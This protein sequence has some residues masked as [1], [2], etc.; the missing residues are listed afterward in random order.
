ME[1]INKAELQVKKKFY[2]MTVLKPKEVDN[3]ELPERSTPPRKKSYEQRIRRSSLQQSPDHFSEAPCDK[4]RSQKDRDKKLIRCLHQAI[5][6]LQ[7]ICFQSS[8][9]LN[10]VNDLLDL[11]KIDQFKFKLHNDYFDLSK[12]VRKAAGTM[13]PEAN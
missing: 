7:L 3:V 13:R 11:A 6:S 10:L 8:M 12:M 1:E 4:C 2:S 5:K 9:I